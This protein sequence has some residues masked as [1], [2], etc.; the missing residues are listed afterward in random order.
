[1]SAT[2]IW[3]LSEAARLLDEPQHRL[4]HL[5]EKNVV[6]PDLGEARGR[7]SSRRFSERN[8]LE[9]AVALK[10]RKL[11]VPV[12]PVAAVIH[13]LRAFENSV[14]QQ[15]PSF[16]LPKSL[17]DK[18]APELSIIITVNQ[19]L[20]FGFLM[21]GKAP[22]YYGGLD[23]ASLTRTQAESLSD[24]GTEVSL[25]GDE[26]GKITLSVTK[27]ARDLALKI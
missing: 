24:L 21:E 13:V 8:L 4:I 23:L 3:T 26:S 6:V 11:M 25:E 9:F 5:C 1:M 20:F 7:G 17:L 18:K 14:T 10:L 2:K 16:T 12:A 22:K 27:V 15:L 19:R